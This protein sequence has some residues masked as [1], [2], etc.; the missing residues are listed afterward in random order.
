MRHQLHLLVAPLRTASVENSAPL[1]RGCLIG[2]RE[3]TLTPGT[4]PEPTE[5]AGQNVEAWDPSEIL[6]VRLSQPF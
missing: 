6:S 3:R 1:T 5:H 4:T 2:V